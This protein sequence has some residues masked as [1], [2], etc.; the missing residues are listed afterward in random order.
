MISKII[1]LEKEIQ[2]EL[3][4]MNALAKFGNLRW[5]HKQSLI[6]LKGYLCSLLSNNEISEIEKSR[7]HSITCC[8]EEKRLNLSLRGWK[9]DSSFETHKYH[10]E[11]ISEYN[12]YL[13]KFNQLGEDIKELTKM[14][15]RYK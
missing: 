15:E 14:I 9:D 7:R 10:A 4:K 1:Q 2:D 3:L 13:K 8:E 11:K 5:E 6:N 12:K